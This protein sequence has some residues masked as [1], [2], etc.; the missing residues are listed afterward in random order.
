MTSTRLIAAAIGLAII[1]PLVIWGG[2]PGTAFVVF[3]AMVVA[4]GEYA[5]MAFPEDVRYAFYWLCLSTLPLAA[6]SLWAPAGSAVAMAGLVVVLTMS[7]VTLSVDESETMEEAAARM[8]RLMVGVVWIGGLFPFLVRLRE[9]ESGLVW[10]V[11]PMVIAWSGD[12]G[13][14]FGGRALGRTALA[15]AIS[16]KKTVEGLAMGTMATVIGVLAVKLAWLPALGIV[17]CLGLA[18]LGSGVAVVGD[19]SESLLKRAHHVKDSGWILPGHG[20][21]LDRVDSLLFVAPLVY[22]WAVIVKGY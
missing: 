10:V 8:G 17:D 11:L 15:P 2:V 16:P 9:L 5:T 18:L 3:T 20:G 13:A 21:M 19:L 14:Y 1:L 22:A 6:A 4:L 7:Q 12:T